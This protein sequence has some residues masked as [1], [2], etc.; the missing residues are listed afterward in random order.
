[1][2][3]PKDAI[4]LKMNISINDYCMVMKDC[5]RKSIHDILLICDLFTTTNHL[6]IK[7]FLQAIG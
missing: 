5:V 2:S 1:M 6:I 4:M 7:L 3:C